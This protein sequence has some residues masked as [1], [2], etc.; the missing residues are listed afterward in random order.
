MLPFAIVGGV[1]NLIEIGGSSSVVYYFN[2]PLQETYSI[3]FII[4]TC[5][6]YILNTL[7]TFKSKFNLLNFAKYFSI[8]MGAMFIGKIAINILQYHTD[9][10]NWV[11]PFLAA[12]FVYVW[13]FFLANKYLDR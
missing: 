2:T 9:F 13:N 6:A 8:Y 3:F 12:P 7:F 10:G 4:A 1:F 11:Y 5:V